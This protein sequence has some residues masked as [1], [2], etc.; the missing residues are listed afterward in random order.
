VLVPILFVLL[1]LGILMIVQFIAARVSAAL[2]GSLNR[3]THHQITR[4]ALGNDTEGEIALG[5][6]NRPAWMPLAYPPLP[7]ELGAKISDY[8]NQISFQSLAKFRNAISTLAFSE[9]EE[10]SGGIITTYLTWRE[11]IHT[12]YFEVLE[13]QDVVAYA[14]GQSDGFAASAAFQ[15]H[16]SHER[17]AR[18]CM[19]LT[20]QPVT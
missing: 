15:A 10:E 9:S 20:P 17:A 6:D 2:S 7:G 3:M 19:T 4:Q 14:I 12:S 13:F 18:W 1:A 11:L 5:A 16:S 8:S